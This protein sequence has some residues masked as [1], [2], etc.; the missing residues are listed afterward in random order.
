MLAAG[1]QH[2]KDGLADTSRR[3]QATAANIANSSNASASR[4]AVLEPNRNDAS[5]A[6]PVVRAGD[7]Y[8][9]AS[10]WTALSAKEGAAITQRL[11]GD[12]QDVYGA[13][14]GSSGLVAL[15]DAL[16]NSLRSYVTAPDQTER[17]TAVVSA[18]RAVIVDFARG[19]AAVDR[20]KA[21]VDQELRATVEQVNASLAELAEVDARIAVGSATRVDIS[22]DLD[23]RDAVVAQLSGALDVQVVRGSNDRIS[24]F[25]TSG[26]TLF[27]RTSR[28]VVADGSGQGGSRTIIID[29]VVTLRGSQWDSGRLGALL[30]FRERVAA[31]LEARLDTTASLLIQAFAEEDLSPSAGAPRAGLFVDVASAAVP[32]AGA[33]IPGLARRIGINPAYDPAVGGRAS[34][35]RD[36]GSAGA[37][38]AANPGGYPGFADRLRTVI[39]RVQ[40]VVP[41][42]PDAGAGAG[43]SVEGMARES[44]AWLASLSS[45]L[46]DRVDR[47]KAVVARTTAALS[48]IVGVQLDE[49]LTLMLSLE[50][51]FQ[52]NGRLVSA[53]DDLYKSLLAMAA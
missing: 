41:I 27:E 9:R 53:F 6:S 24:V 18:A 32:A 48:A 12:V 14:D 34:L 49:E 8:V 3:L 31:P 22:D 36:A 5:R 10:H 45:D 46:T 17:A 51:A 30:A 47:S 1:L 11:L 23:Q 28:S 43:A 40:R 13:F 42:S 39:D 4:K 7:D 37:A 15:T 44:V 16:V 26:A 33:S 29:D 52:A 2:A 50:R 25:T 20:V 38:Y 35:L 21:T 19:I